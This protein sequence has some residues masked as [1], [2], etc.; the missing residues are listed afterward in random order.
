ML[1]SFKVIESHHILWLPFINLQK[2]KKK[3][4]K[5]KKFFSSITPQSSQTIIFRL[6][7]IFRVSL[8]ISYKI[9]LGGLLY[10]L[11]KHYNH[12]TIN[13]ILAGWE[14]PTCCLCQ[15]KLITHQPV[16][17]IL[18]WEVRKSHTL[19]IYIYIFCVIVS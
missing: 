2:K 5:K 12:S 15:I 1:L 11:A 18:Y 6:G 9:F 4:K 10:Y 16:W 13:L 7:I 17:V 3:K 14:R 19:Y 8:L